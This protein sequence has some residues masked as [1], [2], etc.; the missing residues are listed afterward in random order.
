MNINT[1]STMVDSRFSVQQLIAHRIVRGLKDPSSK[2]GKG[3]KLRFALRQTGNQ[4][5]WMLACG[6]SLKGYQRCYGLDRGR[7]IWE[8]D[9]KVLNECRER[10][11][12]TPGYRALSYVRR[13][14]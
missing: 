11:Y 3:W 6:G 9:L 12:K 14:K 7:A 13:Q 4:V 8:A 1:A 2:G 10:L 5:I